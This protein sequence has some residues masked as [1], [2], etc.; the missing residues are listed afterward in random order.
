MET[1]KICFIG[2]LKNY[3]FSVLEELGITNLEYKGISHSYY[4]IDEN[5][6]LYRVYL[7][8][9]G[10]V[11]CNENQFFSEWINFLKKMSVSLDKTKIYCEGCPEL[12]QVL[13][14]IASFGIEVV[15]LNYGADSDAHFAYSVNNT[16]KIGFVLQNPD[17]YLD[18][19][20]KKVTPSQFKEAWLGSFEIN[21]KRLCCRGGKKFVEVVRKLS[22]L[23]Y[24]NSIFCG[25]SSDYYYFIDPDDCKDLSRNMELNDMI[26]VSPQVFYD[27]VCKLNGD[28][29]PLDSK[30]CCRGSEDLKNLFNYL[31][32]HKNIKVF[33]Y[34]GEDLNKYYWIDKCSVVHAN[35]KI[36]KE[37]KLVDYNLFGIYWEGHLH[38][39]ESVTKPLNDEQAISCKTNPE[40]QIKLSIKKPLNIII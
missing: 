33:P 39:K 1:P 8:P 35:E 14:Q 20:Y 26:E 23:G 10:Y 9:E 30:I 34:T 37:Y 15:G 6:E 38:D 31:K 7:L 17:F 12:K 29:E 18:R 3:N 36:P 11:L 40:I 25:D 22:D 27:Y 5:L 19:G 4:Y 13:Q 28:K 21:E 24:L 2:P 32:E 16:G